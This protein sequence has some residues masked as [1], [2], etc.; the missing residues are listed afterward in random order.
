M[1]NETNHDAWKQIAIRYLAYRA[2]TAHELKTHLISKGCDSDICTLIVEHC[3]SRKWIDDE[4][5]AIRYVE[6]AIHVKR[7]GRLWISRALALK[8]ID[9]ETIQVALD[10][11]ECEQEHKE[12]MALAQKKFASFQEHGLLEKQKLF[13]VL[14]RRGYTLSVT[15][16]V[17]NELFNADDSIDF[18]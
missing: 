15:Q 9:A 17:I 1:T 3:H 6:N 7:K 10:S 14:Q 5:Y 12:A 18:P 8:G 13:R 2:R 11:I 16:K 4:L